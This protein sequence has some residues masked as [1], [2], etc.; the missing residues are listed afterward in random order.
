VRERDVD[1]LAAHHPAER[2]LSKQSRSA[3]NDRSRIE[4]ETSQRLGPA[5]EKDDLVAWLGQL[6]GGME[7]AS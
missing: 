3:T 7:Q 2:D 4:T 1:L 6:V 5:A